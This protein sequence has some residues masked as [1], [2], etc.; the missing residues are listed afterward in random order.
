[1]FGRAASGLRH[2]IAL[3]YDKNTIKIRPAGERL[4]VRVLLV[5]VGL[6]IYIM[7]FFGLSRYL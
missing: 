3:K 4:G 6:H 5:L 1:M 7:M 2:Y